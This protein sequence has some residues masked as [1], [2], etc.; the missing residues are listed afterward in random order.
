MSILL[1]G[2]AILTMITAATCAAILVQPRLGMACVLMI[3]TMAVLID[4][5]RGFPLVTKFGHLWDEESGYIWYGE[6]SRILLAESGRILYGRIP[7]WLAAWAM[8][9]QAPVLGHGPHTFFY[10]GPDATGM[11]WPHN[12]YLEL[13]GACPRKKSLKNNAFKLRRDD[14]K[15]SHFSGTRVL[16]G[17]QNFCTFLKNL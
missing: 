3:L 9:L 2:V 8:F 6:S 7:V 13:L 4:G 12:L 16:T 14:F 1:S 15:I 11:G 10:T 5:L 17:G